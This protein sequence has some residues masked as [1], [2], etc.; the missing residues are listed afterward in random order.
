MNCPY[1]EILKYLYSFRK[2]FKVI[3]ILILLCHQ[4]KLVLL[5]IAPR[6]AIPILVWYQYEI[7]AKTDTLRND[8][9]Q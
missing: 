3:E 5:V 8:F 7:F 4:S 6:V 1:V 2:G 9:I